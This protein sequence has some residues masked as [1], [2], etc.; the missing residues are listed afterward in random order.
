M[1]G[2]QTQRFV[3][4][5]HLFYIPFFGARHNALYMFRDFP[6][7]LVTAEFVEFVLRV[8]YV[9]VEPFC[10]AFNSAFRQILEHSSKRTCLS[11]HFS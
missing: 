10:F 6:H 2:T 9:T 1:Y 11:L 5:G 8:V 4:A 3:C 7:T